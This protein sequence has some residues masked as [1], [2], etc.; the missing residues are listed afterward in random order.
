MECAVKVSKDES[1]GLKKS[2]NVTSHH[3]FT[4]YYKNR[5]NPMLQGYQAKDAK[6][7]YKIA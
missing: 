5:T 6:F 7:N 4:L 3:W 2:S 1:I